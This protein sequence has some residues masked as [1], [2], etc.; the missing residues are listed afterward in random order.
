YGVFDEKRV[1]AAGP[2][3]GPFN[4]RGIRI[5]VPICEDM[6]TPDVCECLAET[7]SEILLSPNGSPFEQNKEDVRLN[8]GIARVVETGLPFVYL[9]QVG[10]QDE[11]VFD[12][13]SFVL[14]VNRSLPVQ[15][16]AWESATVLTR[17]RKEGGVWVCEP[18]PKAAIPDGL[19]SLYQAMVL[20]L[21]DYV[22]KNRFPGVVLGLSG[23]ID[24]ALSAA[25]AV[26][27]LG[28]ARV[29]CV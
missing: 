12:G 4:V 17:W 25:V 5:G 2:M 9:N 14:N 18:G 24:S 28:A 27:A 10:G 6:W 29:R 7:G 8:L 26:D 22:T 19:E 11:L 21:R 20:G 3:P 1:F 16:P 13:G 15:M 23:G